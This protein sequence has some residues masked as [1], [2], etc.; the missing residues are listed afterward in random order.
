MPVSV[1]HKAPT[2]N[3]GGTHLPH[4]DARQVHVRQPTFWYTAIPSRAMSHPGS[5]SPYALLINK[6]VHHRVPLCLSTCA[7]MGGC[8]P[9]EAKHG[10]K[11]FWPHIAYA[12]RVSLIP[13]TVEG[14]L[15]KSAQEARHEAALEGSSLTFVLFCVLAG[16]EWTRSKVTYGGCLRGWLQGRPP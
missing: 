12:V 11:S 13:S 10:P 8:P 14:T 16:S 3:N 4:M 6:L 7:L 5:W 15:A 2:N 9:S 1:S